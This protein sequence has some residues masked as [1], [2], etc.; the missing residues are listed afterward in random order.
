MPRGLYLARI[1]PLPVIRLMRER[2]NG[3]KIH[4]SGKEIIMAKCPVCEMQTEN[5][6]EKLCLRCGW[7]FKY[8]LG[9]MSQEE[10]AIYNRKLE[11]CRQNWQALQAFKK[12]KQ[13]KSD[14]PEPP[15]TAK[16]KEPVT[17]NTLY[18][19]KT[20]VPDLTRDPFETVKEFQARI[21]GHRPVPAG[22]AT[23]IKEKYDIETGRFP[24]K[25]LWEDWT[26]NVGGMP[27]S[28]S[29]LHLIAERDLASA[30]YE[31]SST[32]CLFLRLE[33]EGEMVFAREPELSTEK[34]ALPVKVL[35]GGD[36]WTEQVTGM[37][38]IYVP[39]GT[40]MMGDTF[41]EGH[42]NEKPVHEVQLDG[43]YIGKYP[44]TQGQWKK[45]TGNNPAKFQK[46]DDYPVE[47]VSWNDAQ[48]FV[49]K[50][51]K[52]NKGKYELRLP[53]EAEWEYAARSR[54][55][56]ERYAGRNDIDT[57]AWYDKNSGGSSHLVGRKAPNGLGIHDMSG[58]VEEWCQDWYGDYPS[59]SVK[60][61]KG[62]NSGSG[63]VLRGGCWCNSLGGCRSATRYG[64][65]PG[66]RDYYLGFR[67]ALSPCQQ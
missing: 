65:S 62:S 22:K 25:V 43:F 4:K 3:R 60:N 46:G 8:I 34:G 31:V 26:G 24:M 63:R 56:K 58:N 5:D 47:Q 13:P 7:E 59:D 32:Y 33:T 57:V 45:V 21:S 16:E 15:D 27:D 20:P 55:K 38:F 12:Q 52:M 2:G 9:G 36:I 39:E 14:K 64:S 23:L 50:L 29:D 66:R 18:S 37:E 35:K 40:F 30:I 44:V 49:R 6:N 67:L 61:P 1:N 10:E 28:N 53:T 17:E 54:G 41:G 48:E 42:D 19:E 11:I 51:A